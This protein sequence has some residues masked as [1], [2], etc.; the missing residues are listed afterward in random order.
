M[1]LTR[2]DPNFSLVTPGPCNAKCGF[3]FWKETP[4]TDDYFRKLDNVMSGNV[5]PVEC[6]QISIT[7][8]E[9][10]ASK[11]LPK[12]LNRINKEIFKKVVLTSNGFRL[13]EQL[14]EMI[15]IVDCLNISRHH[16][17][18]EANRSVFR[19]PGVPLA[20][21][22][23]AIVETAHEYGIDVTFNC[24]TTSIILPT[25]AK[26]YISFAKE[27]GADHVCFRK[28]HGSLDYTETEQYF[29]GRYPTYG[30]SKCPVC[31]KEEQTI[32]GMNVLWRGGSLEPSNDLNGIYEFIM[33]QDGRMTIDW[34]GKKEFDKSTYVA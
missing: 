12:I 26:R 28:P 5:L 29:L 4:I 32:D 33:Q 1:K 9:P 13:L 31:R 27:M 22:L 23:K 24:V 2:K 15:G 20:G 18:D 3:C 7:G 6:N 11:Y 21:K 14:P 17:D 16:F 10:T 8:G 19:T 25:D 34:D 30:V